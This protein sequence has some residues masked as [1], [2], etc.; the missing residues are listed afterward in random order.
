[1]TAEPKNGHD[2][3]RVWVEYATLG[4]RKTMK[5]YLGGGEFE[6]LVLRAVRVVRFGGPLG[7]GL[8]HYAG[9]GGNG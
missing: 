7:E 9:E 1:M 4:E 2:G 8:A 5:R 6:Y 3:P